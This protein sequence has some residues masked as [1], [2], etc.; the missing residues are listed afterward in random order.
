[1]VGL[2]SI[3]AISAALS[4]V[5]GYVD[6]V[7]RMLGASATPSGGTGCGLPNR[8]GMRTMYLAYWLVIAGGLAASILIGLTAQ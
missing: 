7:L 1:M 3:S 2:P 4:S 5:N 8:G 6:Q